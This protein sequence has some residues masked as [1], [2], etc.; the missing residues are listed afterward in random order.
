MRLLHWLECFGDTLLRLAPARFRDAFRADIVGTFRTTCLA[1]HRERGWPGLVFA[2]I[3]ELGSIGSSAVK[4]RFGGGPAIS[5]GGPRRDGER[6]NRRVRISSAIGNDLRLAWRSIL[7]NKL[8]VAIAVATLALGIGVN[9]AVF[10]ILDS[11]IIRPMPFAH[12]DQLHEIW[13]LDK[14]GFSY[15]RLRR[16]LF[17]EWRKQADLFERFEGYDIT[18]F[19]YQ[20][21]RGADMVTGATTT[22]GLLSMLG[23]PPLKGRIFGAGDGRG[24][25]DAL[26]VIGE[27]F[28]REQLQRDPQ[29]I[30]RTITLND[31][32]HTIIG[33]MPR[34]FAFPNDHAT[35]WVPYDVEAPPA[36]RAVRPIA[37]T[38]FVRR[39][40]SLSLDALKAAIAARGEAV[41]AAAGITSVKSA[42]LSA[43]AGVFDARLR[44]SLLVLGGAVLFLLLIVCAN[45]AN[46]SLSRT[47]VRARDFAVR[48]SLGASRRDLIRE[49]LVENG[50]VGLAGALGG[51]LVA[52]ATLTVV[53]T[54]MPEGMLIGTMNV[55]DLDGRALLF[56]AAIGVITPLL[57]GLAPAL[58]ASKPSVM[59]TLKS[60]SRSTT[61]SMA[62]RRLRNLLVI[63]EVTLAIVLLVGAALMARSFAKLQAVDRGFDAAHLVV[64]R[65]GLPSSGYLDPMARDRFV[66]EMISRVAQ[67]PGVTAATAGGIP[68][69]SSLI[70]FGKVETSAAPGKLTKELILPIYEVWPGYFEA[71]GIPLKAGR[72]FQD[73]DPRLSVIVSESFAKEQFPAGNAINS[74]MRF[75]DATDWRTIIGVAG[76]VRQLD[77]DD[78]QG[79]YEFYYPLKRAAD[80]PSPAVGGPVD[81]IIQYRNIVVRAT[82]VGST[83][84]RLRQI[85]HDVDRTVVV[86]KVEPVEQAFSAAI[87]RPR[88]TFLMMVI[89]GGLGLV[90]AT[91]GIYGVLSYGVAQRRREIGI[92]LALGAQPQSVGRL[93]LR[94]GLTLTTIGLAIG[95][96]TALALVRVMRTLLYEVEPT[97]PVA[98]GGVT[99]LLL[100]TAIVA[101]WRPARQA[102]RVD[103]VA[104]LRE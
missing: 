33:V 96:G 42:T 18:S 11:T 17:L 98:V 101:S 38:A 56:T 47:L 54:S 67:L 9:A 14:S 58:L 44:R 94:N 37:L 63:G 77:M 2:G 90:L 30:G 75:E 41:T 25:T 81:A 72:G 48:A 50:L 26:V 55:I 91:A 65:V 97:D 88:L 12:A 69:D 22:P 79:S 45:V 49:T 70:A 95:L 60:D 102:M 34:S 61:G 52:A 27:R 31:I 92:R 46:L 80:W 29:V 15:P 104:L 87:M 10:S 68:P 3:T 76:E 93:V 35:F 83:V 99:L 32:T 89:L 66:G 21:D 64:L 62:A 4:E 5:A 59:E 8:S 16:P 84:D 71:T 36:N 19:T 85:V 74:K 40:A 20:T 103:P 86:W 6:T 43:R 53:T 24:G 100:A 23:T 57:F 73:G 82:D 7:A 78:K 39:P 51:L 28:W 13:A 1:A